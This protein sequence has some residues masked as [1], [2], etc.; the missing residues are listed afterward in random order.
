MADV[1][2]FDFEVDDLGP[3][4]D[5]AP[6]PG[7]EPDELGDPSDDMPPAPPFLYGRSNPPISSAPA[8]TAVND[9]SPEDWDCT[10]TL[11]VDWGETPSTGKITS[12]NEYQVVGELGSGSFG[13]VFEVERRVGEE[14]W[15]RF[16]LKVFS[17][18]RLKRVRRMRGTGLDMVLREIDIMRH[19]YHRH[20][21]I[22][23]EVRTRLSSILAIYPMHLTLV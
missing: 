20:V 7:F 1:T 11:T 9:S 16:A 19:L 18:S 3:P 8:P 6:Q 23:F 4:P 17:K 5:Q 2:Y 12:A 21:V 10:E 22:L 13:Q 14:P 15:R